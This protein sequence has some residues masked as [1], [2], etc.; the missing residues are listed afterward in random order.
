MTWLDDIGGRVCNVPLRDAAH[1][2]SKRMCCG[3]KL[4]E[5]VGK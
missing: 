5:E 4:I 1:P 2:R 3:L